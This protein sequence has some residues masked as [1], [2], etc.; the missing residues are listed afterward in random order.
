MITIQTQSKKIV[1]LLQERFEVE[2]DSSEEAFYSLHVEA[3]EERVRS[4][5]EEYGYILEEIDGIYFAKTR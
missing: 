5:F 2:I 4:C 3:S 1:F